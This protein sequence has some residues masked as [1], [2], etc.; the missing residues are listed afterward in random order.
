MPRH[1]TPA[2][3]PHWLSGNVQSRVARASP[4]SVWSRDR[5]GAWLTGPTLHGRW[6]CGRLCYGFGGGENQPV[7]ELTP[8]NVAYGGR[9][10]TPT[11]RT[12]FAITRRTSGW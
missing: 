3:S 8:R 10:P 7:G 12:A 11:Q 5:T 1:P 2:T 4:R 9:G 6:P